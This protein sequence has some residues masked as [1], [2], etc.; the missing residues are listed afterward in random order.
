[1]VGE[2]HVIVR[3]RSNYDTDGNG[4][5][6]FIDQSGKQYLYTQFP[7][8]YCHRVF[9][10]FDQPD[11]KARMKLNV[12]APSHWSVISNE[13]SLYAAPF[14]VAEYLMNTSKL[15]SDII[16]EYLQGCEG[17]N[18]HFHLQTELLSSYLFCFV[19]GEF[20]ELVCPNPYK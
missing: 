7:P 2:N 20:V 9:P 6:S 1:V 4:C 10:V 14:D 19:A 8:Y 18:M 5:V 12:I 17:Y 15:A 13:S 3:Y 11:L 16:G